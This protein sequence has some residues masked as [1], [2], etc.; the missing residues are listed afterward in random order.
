MVL[1]IMAEQTHT[2]RKQEEA[3][4]KYME[5]LR[6]TE[7]YRLL[8]FAFLHGCLSQGNMD[9]YI[10]VANFLDTGRIEGGKFNRS[11]YLNGK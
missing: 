4:Q 10:I 11:Y 8:K 6:D 9:F 7:A 1:L 5:E 2:K 3:H